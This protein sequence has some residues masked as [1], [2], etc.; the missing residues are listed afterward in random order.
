M[1]PKIYKLLKELHDEY[2][3]LPVTDYPQDKKVLDVH[4]KL[5]NTVSELFVKE[6][7]AQI[8]QDNEG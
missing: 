2:W 1:T 8:E 6:R 4:L 3:E 5:W 7:K